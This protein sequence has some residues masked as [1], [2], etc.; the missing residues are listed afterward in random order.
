MRLG[1]FDTNVAP[2]PPLALASPDVRQQKQQRLIVRN[3]NFHA[4]EENLADAFSAFGPLAEVR[5]LV[6]ENMAFCHIVAHAHGWM[7]RNKCVVYVG[8]Y[9]SIMCTS[10]LS[11]D[12]LVCSPQ[13]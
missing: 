9:D 10:I 11:V 1:L 4:K 6:G 12:C 3:L 7:L 5:I 2:S 8:Q 13:V